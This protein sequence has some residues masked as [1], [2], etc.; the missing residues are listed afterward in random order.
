MKPGMPRLIALVE[1]ILWSGWIEGE[2]PIS[3]LLVAPAG[4]GKTSLLE[5]FESEYAPFVSDCT[6][7]EVSKILKEK[8]S[9]SHLLIGDFISV[10]RHKKSTTDLTMNMISQLA[11]ETL[12]IDAFTGEM[13]SR[14]L[15]IISAIPPEDLKDKRIRTALNAG[16]FASRFLIAKYDYQ[17]STIAAIHKYIREGRYREEQKSK[18][19]KVGPPPRKISIDPNMSREVERL[20]IMIKR[21]PIGARAHHYI[22]TLGLSIAACDGSKRMAARHFQT[23]TE[24]SEFFTQRGVML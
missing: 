14:R 18:I 7:R 8:R 13:T 9:A 24:M 19:L 5:N 23:L 4:A 3:M 2:R 20:G 12:R 15:G 11:G 16:G 10:M 17:T 21:D 1:S 22:R 6:S